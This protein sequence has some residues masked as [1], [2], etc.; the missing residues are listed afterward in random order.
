MEQGVYGGCLLCPLYPLLVRYIFCFL[1]T[2]FRIPLVSHGLLSC[3][4]FLWLTSLI[5]AC[6]STILF[7]VLI[8][9]CTFHLDSVLGG[10][11]TSL[12][13]ANHSTAKIFGRRVG[14]H[15]HRRLSQATV[16]S[17]C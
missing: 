3:L 6:L 2:D 7:R 10:K 16:G 14:K 17:N 5:A 11:Q 4:C 1:I 9:S 15:L 12:A 13:L 8:A